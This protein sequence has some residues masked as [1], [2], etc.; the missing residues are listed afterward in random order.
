MS[1]FL[2]GS[3]ITHQT[4]LLSL[5]VIC[6]HSSPVPM[7]WAMTNRAILFRAILALGLGTGLPAMAQSEAP[8]KTFTDAVHQV[9]SRPVYAHGEFGLEVYSLDTGKVMYAMNSQRLFTPGS[10]T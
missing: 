5:T 1:R 9:T 10:T 6:R 4:F 3:A 2:L 7:G 8:P